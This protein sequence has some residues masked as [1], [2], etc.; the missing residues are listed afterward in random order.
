MYIST[1]LV[2]P[3]EA[4]MSHEKLSLINT[5]L[6]DPRSARATPKTA[7]KALMAEMVLPA[8]I[9]FKSMGKDDGFIWYGPGVGKFK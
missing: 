1:L 9:A 5:Q 2:L 4:V 8:C 3:M 6:E 7:L